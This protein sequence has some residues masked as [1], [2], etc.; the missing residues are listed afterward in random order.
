M[1][2][3]QAR[4]CRIARSRRA[5][6]HLLGA[7]AFMLVALTALDGSAQQLTGT[8]KK[9]KDSGAVALGYRE[10]SFPFSYINK[11]GEPL[12]YSIDLCLAVVDEVRAELERDNI[13]IVYVS[14]TPANRIDK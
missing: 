14:V 1:F 2:A 5:A 10:N 9:I 13:K 11:R 6:R 7:T 3:A 12:G 8:L 4:F